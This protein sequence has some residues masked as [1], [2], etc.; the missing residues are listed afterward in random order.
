MKLKRKTGIALIASAAAL[1][2]LLGTAGILEASRRSLAASLG[3][4]Q[5]A[6]R[7]DGAAASQLSCFFAEGAGYAPGRIY[8]LERAIDEAMTAA[9]LSAEDGA[10][11]WYHA[12]SAETSLYAVTS[13][14][15][16]TLRVTVFGGD[17]FYI[18]Q[19]ALVCGA[20]LSPGGANAGYVFLDENAAWKLFGATD[21][22][23]MSVTVGGSEY[24]VCGVGA[25]PS[26]TVYDEAYGDAPRA[27]ILFDS[28]AAAGVSEITAYEAVLPNPISGFAA[29]IV[30]KNLP[31]DGTSGVMVE[32][33]V[34]FGI[35]A[36][37]K[38][39]GT[40]STLGVRTSPVTFP[41]WENIAR[42]AEYRCSS[43]LLAECIL[44][45]AALLECLVWLGIAWKPAGAA[46]LHLFHTVR[47]NAGETYNQLTR[48]K[49]RR[50]K[51]ETA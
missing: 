9:S 31:V 36:L 13:R 7:W 10:R 40:R 25:V 43:L 6:G 23:G 14:A 8:S 1:V 30:Q 11:L 27:Y 26:G 3:D 47:E 2:L 24:T 20:Y 19:P 18:H 34:R 41:W 29:D 44:A 48:P 49:K 51:G 15:S 37:W 16:A 5:A 39:L 35:P 28:P 32:N 12:Y 50:D 4:Q 17:Y 33:S 38:Y 21:I 42:V 22:A 45:G 46:L